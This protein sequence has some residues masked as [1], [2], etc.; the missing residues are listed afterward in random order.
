MDRSSRTTQEDLHTQRPW[1]MGDVVHESPAESTAKP[2]EPH[3]RHTTSWTTH[4]SDSPWVKLDSDASATASRSRCLHTPMAQ[5]R[6]GETDPTRRRVQV[7]PTDRGIGRRWHTRAEHLIVGR[8][9]S[10][11][12]ARRLSSERDRPRVPPSV[13]HRPPLGR[14]EM[15]ARHAP[16]AEALLHKRAEVRMEPIA[17]VRSKRLLHGFGNGRCIWVP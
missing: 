14:C 4:P 11:R 15:R 9:A 3:S 16:L 8:P 12:G 10:G 2:V 6:P 5:V 1:R 13:C 17:L 7:A